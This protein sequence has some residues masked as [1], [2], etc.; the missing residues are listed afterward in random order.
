MFGALS[1]IATPIGNLKDMT[2]RALE[3]LKSADVVVCET[4]NDTRR[5]LTHF[6]IHK[7]VMVWRQRSKNAGQILGLL[8]EGKYVAYVTCA[9]TP[10]ISDPGGTLV[11]IVSRELP[12]ARITAVPGASAVTA[13]LS[14]A[15]FP[16]DHFYFWGFPPSKKGRRSYF[17]ELS[18]CPVTAVFFESPYRILRSLR[19]LE[20]ATSLERRIVVCRELTK[21]YETISRGTIAAVLEKVAAEPVKGEYTII[22]APRGKNDG[23]SNTKVQMSKQF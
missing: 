22:L 16:A 9:G 21:V 13:A 6:Q 2:L 23:M 4:P 19:E 3:T 10:V 15:G 12:G 17:L 5:L 20:S 18:Q 7:P 1:I 8:R 11:E 14:I